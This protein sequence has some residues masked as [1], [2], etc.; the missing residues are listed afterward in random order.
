M[1]KCSE[2]AQKGYMTTRGHKADE[3]RN[4]LEN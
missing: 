4:V 1:S 2:E 3:G